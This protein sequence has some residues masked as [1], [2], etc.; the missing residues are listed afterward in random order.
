[1]LGALLLLLLLLPPPLLRRRR[2]LLLLLLLPLGRRKR[3]LRPRQRRRYGLLALLP[4]LLPLRKQPAVL[5]QQL[6]PLRQ[7]PQQRRLVRCSAARQG[8]T[9]G[10]GEWGGHGRT[11]PLRLGTAWGTSK[12]PL[13]LLFPLM[14]L[15]LLLPLFLLL[16]LFPLMLL[17]LTGRLGLRQVWGWGCCWELGGCASSGSLGR[18]K[19]REGEQAQNQKGYQWPAN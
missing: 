18:A 4:L 1:M 13:L 17:V 11:L 8:G 9:P 6:Q 19:R 15:L 5:H 7:L 14:L 16:L 10:S 3:V 2:H 12:Q